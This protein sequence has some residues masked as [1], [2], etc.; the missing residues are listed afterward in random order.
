MHIAGREKIISGHTE[1][2]Y[3]YA[4]H[5]GSGE[6]I[7]ASAYARTSETIVSVSGYDHPGMSGAELE[8]K[9]LAFL[10]AGYGRPYQTSNI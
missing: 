3:R 1:A 5:M 6:A 9:A 8:A 4:H 10:W 2:G 7:P